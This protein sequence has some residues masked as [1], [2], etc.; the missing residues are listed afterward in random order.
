MPASNE[1]LLSYKRT[2]LKLIPVIIGTIIFAMSNILF[3]KGTRIFILVRGASFILGMA[4]L[5]SFLMEITYTNRN[6][7]F[8]ILKSLN[9]SSVNCVCL[10]RSEIISRLENKAYVFFIVSNQIAFSKFGVATVYKKRTFN[11][12]E[13]RVVDYKYYYIDEIRNNRVERTKYMK[14]EQFLEIIDLNNGYRDCFD[15]V[16][17]NKVVLPKNK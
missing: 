11:Q 7:K 12:K 17:I 6:R 2:M 15:V 5:M 9:T 3:T 10:P 14:L 1:F 16:S 8:R 4:F 13:K